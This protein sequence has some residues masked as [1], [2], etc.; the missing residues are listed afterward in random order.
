M[1]IFEI[2]LNSNLILRY[3]DPRKF[4]M[5]FYSKD[6]PLLSNKLLINLGPEPLENKFNHEYLYT[7]SRNR[8]IAIKSY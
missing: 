3:N 4:G 6:S 7:I 5:I 2:Y 1:I 8:N